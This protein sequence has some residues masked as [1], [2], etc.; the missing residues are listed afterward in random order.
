[1]NALSAHQWFCF[2]WMP[3]L[4]PLWVRKLSVMPVESSLAAAHLALDTLERTD[5]EFAELS[6]ASWV[7]AD[8]GAIAHLAECAGFA[9]YLAC[10]SVMRSVERTKQLV[11][12]LS[13]QTLEMRYHTP[14]AF[15]FPVAACVDYEDSLGLDPSML[16]ACVLIHAAHHLGSAVQERVKLKLPPVPE[17]WRKAGMFGEAQVMCSWLEG[18]HN[19]CNS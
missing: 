2:F 9:A 10:P 4:H 7:T 14:D 15:V 1:M 11:E 16:G 3:N 13:E 17:T 6:E 5:K 19:A 12:S 8:L 18:I